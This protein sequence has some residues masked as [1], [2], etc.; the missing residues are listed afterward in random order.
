MEFSTL[1]SGENMRSNTTFINANTKIEGNIV[2]K[3]E[4]KIQ[5]IINGDLIAKNIVIDR[6]A[7]CNGKIDSE[8]AIISGQF[9][10]EIKS[11]HVE[12]KSTA[13]INGHILKSTISVDAGA[14]I[15]AH[16]QSRTKKS[17]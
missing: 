6:Q 8:V 2:S 9:D 1:N 12:I 4:L 3:S 10:G 14:K 7:I 17:A 5:G 11:N 16:I 15:D 13:H